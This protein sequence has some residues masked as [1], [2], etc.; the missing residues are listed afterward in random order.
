MKLAPNIASAPANVELVSPG[1]PGAK[2]A[3]RTGGQTVSK[4]SSDAFESYL[5]T[6]REGP[7]PKGSKST[8]DSRGL[9]PASTDT[10][11]LA[12]E[13]QGV[14]PVVSQ[15]PTL[16]APD[17]APQ[18][19]VPGN[20]DEL[21]VTTH[22]LTPNITEQS[23][24]EAPPTPPNLEAMT[25]AAMGF[26]QQPTILAEQTLPPNDV[27]DLGQVVTAPVISRT[28]GGQELPWETDGAE[29]SPKSIIPAPNQS[30][31]HPPIALPES[32]G[33]STGL[34]I[35]APD[36]LV[37]SS[38]T[39][40]IVPAASGPTSKKSA[41]DPNLLSQASNL[42]EYPKIMPSSD[43]MG[44][45]HPTFGPNEELD[46]E[47]VQVNDP[48]VS[49][50]PSEWAEI[51]LEHAAPITNG[52]G[53]PMFWGELP[54]SMIPKNPNLALKSEPFASSPES[55]GR[56]PVQADG[57]LLTD[58]TNT[59]VS[60]NLS[61][62]PRLPTAGRSPF[63]MDLRREQSPTW[64]L[65]Q[66]QSQVENS[67]LG[68]DQVRLSFTPSVVADTL[69]LLGLGQGADSSASTSVQG[70]TLAWPAPDLVQ[71]KPELNQGQS[72]GL[73]G[74]PSLELEGLNSPQAISDR[75]MDPRIS[76]HILS[77]SRLIG[78]SGLPSVE[79]SANR[80]SNRTPAADSSS[81]LTSAFAES[82]SIM[83]DTLDL[84]DLLARD[85]E[86]Q[87]ETGGQQAF[88][89]H[90][91]N[92]KGV[93]GPDVQSTINSA[94]D[95]AAL[96]TH[97]VERARFLADQ[98]GGSIQIDLG[99][100]KLGTI[101]LIVH[102]NQDNVEVKILAQSREA[103]DLITNEMPQLKEA[104]HQRN[105]D[106]RTVEV[107]VRT[108]SSWTQSNQFQ[109]PYREFQQSQNQ[110]DLSRDSGAKATRVRQGP[111]VSS[112]YGIRAS[113]MGQIQVLV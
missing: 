37:L 15:Q 84:K 108:G 98:G 3:S 102:A 26:A 14:K 80:P 113:G 79:R 91:Q 9:L 12:L 74:Q 83:S 82:T 10:K 94:N 92:S 77:S 66:S 21:G 33:A 73:I 42:D 38:D 65:S 53:R 32:K 30:I 17:T 75:P 4:N 90:T 68:K 11:G 58:P 67:S 44:F 85:K 112:R 31:Q 110:H 106:L 107:A 22:F 104:L 57:N 56:D 19:L 55:Q 96:A 54:Q 43:G 35:K 18:A 6:P 76:T 78:E 23:I 13:S 101:N 52:R 41:V 50:V 63:A 93:T 5:E 39:L 36:F 95:N 40:P 88:F 8:K 100:E 99:S 70:A 48:V 111:Q 61:P 109:Q 47:A 97:L 16:A 60:L 2:V 51:G 27:Q 71:A 7:E 28:V 103:R 45:V 64:A 86:K 81:T 46:L 62:T 89:A 1:G 29:R 34:A 69:S 59:G 20:G 87:P 49:A 24:P 72:R 25:L 105:I